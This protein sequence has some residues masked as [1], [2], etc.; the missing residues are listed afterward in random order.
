MP[1]GA[2]VPYGIPAGGPVTNNGKV[3]PAFDPNAVPC[4]SGTTGCVSPMPGS[5]GALMDV[6]GGHGSRGGCMF[7]HTPHSTGKIDATATKAFSPTGTVAGGPYGTETFTW[8]ANSVGNQVSGQIYLWNRAI[9]TVTYKTWDGSTF[10]SATA[11]GPDRPE[12]HTLLC[13]TCHDNSMSSY[14]M[15]ANANGQHGGWGVPETGTKFDGTT[16]ITNGSQFTEQDPGTTALNISNG[17]MTFGQ[18]DLSRSHPVH[19]KYRGSS[20]WKVTINADHSV[21]YVDADTNQIGDS[22]FYGHPARLYSDGTDV[23]VECT[24]CHNPHRQ[25]SPAYKSA[26]GTYVVG[27][28]GTTENYIRGPF[29][30]TDGTISAG[31]CRS[32]HYSKSPEYVKNNGVSK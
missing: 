7:C 12:V 29:S 27:A 13:M 17:V 9:T 1:V 32:C 19:A 22:G 14:A 28:F 11:T 10:S 3:S 6:L 18:G 24:S 25:T 26:S 23:Y 5:S 20:L 2:G 16:P 31:F 8:S 30:T 15:T 21:S 4:K